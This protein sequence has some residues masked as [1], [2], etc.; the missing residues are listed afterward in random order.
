M[1]KKS[2]QNISTYS[3]YKVLLKME[4][5]GS[6]HSVVFVTNDTE[7]WFIHCIEYK[8]KS[9][10]IDHDDFIIEKDMPDWVIWHEGMGWKK[11]PKV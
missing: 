3:A 7:G 5:T 9:G 11:V 6:P 1:A 4:K 10:L 2:T 8:T